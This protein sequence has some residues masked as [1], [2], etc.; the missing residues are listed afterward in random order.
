[1]IVFI[2]LC[3][4]ISLKNKLDL[5]QDNIYYLVFYCS[6]AIFTFLIMRIHTRII[7]YSNT[8]DML[9]VFVAVLVSNVAFMLLC[10]I[11]FEPYL[12]ISLV[13]LGDIL[14]INFFI[15]S[16]L[17]MGMRI[18]IKDLFIYLEEP[19]VTAN[20]EN[21]LIFGSGTSSIL[22]KK[23]VESQKGLMLQVQGFIDVGTDKIYKCI[24][25]K[26]VYPVRALTDLKQKLAIKT[27]LITAEDL[28][29]AGKRAAVEKCIELGIKVIT[30][31]PSDQWL[32]GTPSLNQFKDLKIEDLLEREPIELC[33]DHILN[34]FNGKRIL[35]TG[36]AGSI[37]S[38]IVRQ[39]MCYNPECIIL[40]DQAETP[41][42]D[43]QMEIED[44]KNSCKT[45]MFIADIQNTARI[46]SLFSLYKP[47]IV[48][49]AA[50]Y[51][52]VPMMENNPT[53]AVLTN[54]WGTKN[55]ADISLEF[56]VEKFIMISTDKAVRP[57]NI[58]GASKRIAEMY[59]Q[60]L[61]EKINDQQDFFQ[62][63]DTG[64]INKTKFIT[65][66]FGNVLGSNGSVIPR[67]KAQIERGGPVTV[68][69]PDITRYFMTIPEAVQLVLEAAIMG[70]GS[71]IFL[72]DMGKPVKIAD[73]AANM[74]KLAGF[75][76]D[77]DIKI[78]FTG[79]RPGEKLYEELLN[80]EEQIIPTYNKDIKISRT[81][82]NCYTEVNSVI[83][84]LLDLSKLNNE[85]L[86][87]AKMKTI[88]P[89]YISNNSQY[90]KLD[91]KFVDSEIA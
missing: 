69:H 43:I 62:T 48:F 16:S 10:N 36:A 81:I 39:V 75:T 14:L 68:T 1:M 87:V 47:Q 66:R 90:E 13:G 44:G 33:K 58:M 6:S 19:A 70:K 45:K 24:E 91:L 25:Q 79:L 3:L 86:M 21:V 51:K 2:S 54:V 74:I 31:P 83:K 64:E 89:D 60:S 52:H 29:M 17:L 5:K 22:I 28:N 80:I 41:L 46:R 23:A 38:E 37:G 40:C 35:V 65:T 30:V 53:E 7:R 20:R 73:L 26:Q 88:L 61:N 78:V 50:A 49:H 63:I 32:N 15:S 85:E 42:H 76:P 72:F 9:R 12:R 84:E 18:V 77:K 55:V 11:L 8:K 57:T 27:M 34:E 59:I 4:A 71:E 56:G 67:F 82:P